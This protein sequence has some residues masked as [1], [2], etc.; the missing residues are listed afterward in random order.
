MIANPVRYILNAGLKIATDDRGQ[1]SLVANPTYLPRCRVAY[2]YAVVSNEDS[3][4]PLLHSPAFDYRKSVILERTPDAAIDTGTSDTSWNCHIT[5]YSLNRI[6]L[7]VTTPKN[8]LAVLSEIYYPSWTAT[9]DGKAAPVYRA[10]YA[11]RAIPV[12]AGHHEI[13]CYF[14]T[15]VFQ[16]GLLLSLVSLALTIGLGAWGFCKRKGE[17]AGTKTASEGKRS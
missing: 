1:M 3:I 8:G 11:L 12:S 13:S 14:S 10:D 9:V 16:R 17:M 5:N 6:D 15:A 7:D 2:N 4:L